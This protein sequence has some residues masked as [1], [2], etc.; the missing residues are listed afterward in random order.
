MLTD[1]SKAF[2]CLPHDLLIAKLHAYGF[3]TSSLKLIHSYLTNRYQRVKINNSFSEYH[4]IKYG[5]P[6]GSILG[7]ILFNIFLCDLFL[8]V[9]DI[10]IASYA[11]DNTPYCTNK[12]P[13]NLKL[14]LKLA[15]EKVFQWFHNNGMKA[16]IDKC[17]FLSSL[18]IASTMTIENFNIKNSTS[19]KLLGVTIDRQLNFNE[20]VCI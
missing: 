10:D 8:I 4:L 9:D 18:D 19:Q 7:P 11:D 6:Q 15:S 12:I 5:V 13:N 14:T 1:L 20:H 17:H 16:N 3:D 2:D